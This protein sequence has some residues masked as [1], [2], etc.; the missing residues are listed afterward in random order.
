ME[1]I[2][3]GSLVNVATA[4][5]QIGGIVFDLPSTSKAV[6]AVMDRG[7]GPVM[8]TVP[9]AALTE[10]AEAG[11]DD[12]ALQL[13]VRRTAHPVHTATRGGSGPGQRHA[14]HTRP[15]MHR[16]TGK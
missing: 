7:R 4:G 14:G 3:V 11:P 2:A 5:P 15:A 13:L 16:T 9:R 1:E 8:W 12:R 6:V 10:R